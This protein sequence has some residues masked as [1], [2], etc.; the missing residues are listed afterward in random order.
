MEKGRIEFDDPT[1]R[2]RKN[3]M[4]KTCQPFD[5]SGAFDSGFKA[6]A[7][8]LEAIGLDIKRP[9]YFD[10]DKMQYIDADGEV[11]SYYD[12]QF[13]VNNAI[14][15]P[16]D[17]ILHCPN[18]G[19]LHVDAPEPDICECGH[20][21]SE[22]APWGFLEGNRVCKECID[23]TEFKIAW[24]NPPHRSH[25]CHNPDCK[26]QNGKPTVFRPADVP[27]YGVAEIKTRGE[28]DTWPEVK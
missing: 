10:G 2:E 14:L 1:F 26:D 18:C 12:I 4:M 28:N 13:V 3:E 17:M 19:T 15:T 11:E 24:N 21:Q 9:I 25:K 5:L 16:V 8:K 7:A 22:H 27:T 20:S 6:A 23:C